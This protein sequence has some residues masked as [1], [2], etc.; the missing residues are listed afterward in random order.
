MWK[1]QLRKVDSFLTHNEKAMTEMERISAAVA[2]WQSGHRF[3]DKE[4]ESA[5]KQLQKLALKAHEYEEI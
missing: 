4:F 1:S 2:Q 5:I 3:A